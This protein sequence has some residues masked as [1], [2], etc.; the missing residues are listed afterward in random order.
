VTVATLGRI[1]RPALASRIAG[2]LDAGSVLLVAGAGYGKTLALEEAIAQRPRRTV[3]L[4]CRDTGGE[5]GR[6]LVGTLEGLRAT[7]PGL[8]DVVGERIAA[9]NEPIDVHAAAAALLAEVERLLVEPVV[10]VFDDA[11]ELARSEEAIALLNRL[12]E[13]RV[14][15]LSLA[16]ATRRPLPLRL[17]KLRAGGRVTEFGPTELSFTAAECEELLRL[18][19]GHAVTDEEIAAAVAASEGWPMGVAT[20]VSRATLFD[21]LAEEVLDRLDDEARLAL[22]DS[23]I[24]ATLS[25]DIAVDTDLLA[26]L[27]RAD[28]SGALSYHPLLRAFLLERLHELRS[29][30]ERA[31]LHAHAADRLAALGRHSEAVDHWIEAGAFRTALEALAGH[32]HELVRTAPRRVGEWLARLP[33]DFEE[34]P[35]RLLL[36][37]QLLW[38]AGRH[39]QAVEPLRGAVAG[40]GAAGDVEREWQA[41]L[42]LADTLVS[43]GAFDQV[44]ALADG[45]KRVGGDPAVAAAGVAWYQV[46]GLAAA[47]HPEEAQALV[48]QLHAAPATAAHYRFLE[49]IAHVGVDPG[50]GRAR[51]TLERL[52]ETLAALERDGDPHGRTPFTMEM[53]VLVLRDLGER[54]E[55]LEW[56]DRCEHE[57]EAVGLGF[58]ARDCQLQRALL[59]AQAGD[60][61]GAELEL[62][63]AGHQRGTGWRGV[64]RPQ[65]EAEIASLRGDAVA[66]VAAAQRALERVTP[67]AVCFRVWATVDMAPLL[68]ANGA[69]DLAHV[70]LARTMKTLDERFPGEAGRLHRAR[71]LAARACLEYEAGEPDAAC[72]SLQRCFIEAAGEADQVVR[73]H[74]PALRNA[75][76]HALAVGAAAPEPVLSAM[77]RAF[78]DGRALLAMVDSPDPAVRRVAL[79][80]GLAAGH[81]AALDRLVDLVNDRDPQVA[82]AAAATHVRLRSAPLPLRFELLGGFRVRRA[83]WELSEAAWARP[84][85]ARVVRFLLLNSGSAVPEDVLF[86][87]FWSDR[88]ADSAR[89][90]L[91]VAISRARK[92]LDLPGAEQS[93]I[94]ARERTYRLR[95]REHDSVDVNEFEHAATDALA[96]T[97]GD[98]HAALAR[99]AALW[100][101]EPLPEDRYAAWS[102]PW[103]TRLMDTY[104]Q[105]L[106]ALV[107]SSQNSGRDHDAVRW[108]R[109]LLEIDPLDEAAHR[110]LMIAYARTGRTS[111]A[112]RQFLEC[113]HALV[114]ELG[115][116][117]SAQ[118]SAVQ[119]RIL[120]GEP[121]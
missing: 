41:R 120:A 98:R 23:S 86:E 113:R 46:I 114:T 35:Q 13:V 91:A 54:A 7:V 109:A 37:G 47:G 104:A 106:G 39:G 24:S 112:L 68:A 92:V 102:L 55:A 89:Q 10:M 80:A 51:A 14:A 42:L 36:D 116:E 100:T 2:A 72:E 69:P 60:L 44:G 25:P 67:G 103:R 118:T 9:V 61:A 53:V 26:G 3:W 73:A 79:P 15:P 62:S 16:I 63:R 28:P 108:G 107:D 4:S 5:A 84:M 75:L 65:A 87:A 66:A 77:Q 32:G 110:R 57:A 12:L 40:F 56:L 101:G 95:L 17:A 119:A 8:A 49:D 97:G 64:H 111:H 74:W 105:L 30:D 52:H 31:Q 96:A 20:A 82:A 81:P 48:T 19:R 59:L 11:E 50:A 83:G 99:A 1:A 38:G 70:A 117:P 6:L 43:A 33:P 94:D 34:D 88:P 18:R 45:W 71:L 22:V 93:V 21:Y 76:A 27:V 78:P 85:A 90:H 29:D 121:V 115:I 58:V